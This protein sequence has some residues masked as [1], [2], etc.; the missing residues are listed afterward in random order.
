MSKTHLSTAAALMTCFTVLSEDSKWW[1]EQTDEFKQEYLKQ[2]PNSKF[3]NSYSQKQQITK[4]EVNPQ[5]QKLK[6]VIERN[7]E[8]EKELRPDSDSRKEMAEEVKSHGKAFSQYLSSDPENEAIRASIRKFNER[9]P[10][11]EEE[12]ARIV[13][14]FE[15]FQQH[16]SGMDNAKLGL[17]VTGGAVTVGALATLGIQGTIGLAAL[18]GICLAAGKVAQVLFRGSE[19]T[20]RDDDSEPVR[21]R[22]REIRIAPEDDDNQPA[23]PA[24]P[25]PTTA[26][27]DDADVEQFFSTLSKFVRTAPIAVDD[28]AKSIQIRGN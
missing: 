22:A 7:E 5:A 3:A 24:L 2:H 25:K 20:R 16:V 6:D 21:V 18:A 4:I 28:W 9:K 19:F 27:A 10:L 12:R 15:R 26:S 8:V 17:A 11:L 23:G 13:E 14:G 1:D